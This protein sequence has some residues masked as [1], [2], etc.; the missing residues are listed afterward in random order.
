MSEVSTP[1]SNNKRGL[2]DSSTPSPT[3]SSIKPPKKTHKL[4]GSAAN[5]DVDAI[6]QSVMSVLNDQMGD[7]KQSISDHVSS[8]VE[9]MSKHIIEVIRESVDK[10]VSSLEDENRRLQD[11][12]K[13]LR[14]ELES[15]KLSFAATTDASEQ[16]SRRNCL[17]IAGIRESDG[18]DTDEIVLKIA[19][20]LNLDLSLADIDRSHRVQPNKRNPTAESST[21]AESSVPAESSTHPRDIIVKFVSYRSR[22]SLFRAKSQLKNN[23]DY[24]K[25]Y[26]NE[27]LTSKR[28]ELF[29]LARQLVKNKAS[30]VIS[31]WTFDGRVHVKYS[32]GSR[33]LINT[34]QDLEMDLQIDITTDIQQTTT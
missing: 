23:A 31:A 25:V 10:R 1:T 20:S 28:A 11:H 5:V 3:S 22:N 18:E 8:R 19:S 9:A 4:D 30:S 2:S 34:K 13:E 14:S 24:S 32:D 7:I 17:K 33:R 12:V 16:Y 29:K 26:I 15:V 27:A 6:T 21:S